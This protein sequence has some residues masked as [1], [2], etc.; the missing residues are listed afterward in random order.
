MNEDIRRAVAYKAIA[1]AKGTFPSAIY[2]YHRSKY[3]NMSEGYDYEASAHMDRALGSF[4]H[5]GQSAHVDLKISGGRF[6]GYDYSSGSHFE[7][8][9]R[10]SSV[11]LY[12]YGEGR[13]FEY[14]S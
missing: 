5:Y 9:T 7:G 2:S 4:Y 1:H 13:Y 10:G 11:S 12:D 3:S 8:T 6:S 14:G